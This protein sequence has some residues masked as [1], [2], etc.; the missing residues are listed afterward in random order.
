MYAWLVPKVIFPLAEYVGGRRMWTEL[1]RMRAV[2]WWPPAEVEAR[3]LGR[4]KSLLA[5]ARQHV[6]YYRDLFTKAGIEAGDIRTPSDLSPVPITTKADLRIAYPA[7]ST[8]ENLPPERRRRMMTSGSTGLP[9]EFFWDRATADVLFGAYLF[10]LEW[11][12]TAIWDARIVMASPAYFY[13]NVLPTSRLRELARRM[14]LGERTWSLPAPELTAAAFRRLVDQ[15]PAGRRYFIRAYPSSIAHLVSQLEGEDS[16]R[17]HPAAVISFAETLTAMNAA[18]IG[19]TFRCPVV[20]YYSSWEVPQM[21]Q[22]C[23]DNP[24]VLHVNSERVILLVVRPDGTP[25]SPGETGRVVVTDLT[26][27]VMP[28]IN[29]FTGDYAVVAPPCPCGRGLP[30]L[31]R[32]EGRDLEVIRTP[33]GRRINGGVLGQFITFVLDAIPYVWEYQ[34]VQTALDAVTLRIVPTTRFTSDFGA[35]V[36]RELGAFLGPEVT[37]SLDVVDRIAL[38][39]SGKRFIIKAELRQPAVASSIVRAATAPSPEAGC[40]P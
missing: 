5:H 34:A 29:Y 8:A 4:L 14:A 1:L 30:S 9:F 38:E 19:R 37:V 15:L 3:A 16:P 12:G 36:E 31:S 13:H 39:P 28:F 7:R 33:A 40:S 6:P 17:R 11:A 20:N 21:A 18:S 23:P 27:Y 32:L 24:D 2:Q 22:T 35:K 10:S 26:N 25:A